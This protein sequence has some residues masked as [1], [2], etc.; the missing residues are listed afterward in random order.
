MQLNSVIIG[1]QLKDKDEFPHRHW[2]E[3]TGLYWEMTPA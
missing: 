1:E 3:M 2:R